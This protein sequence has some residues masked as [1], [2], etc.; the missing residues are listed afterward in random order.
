MT[1]LAP[2]SKARRLP[3]MRGCRRHPSP[4]LPVTDDPRVLRHLHGVRTLSAPFEQIK[5][6]WPWNWMERIS[7]IS[8]TQG[9]PPGSEL[10]KVILQGETPDTK[11]KPSASS[12]GNGVDKE[13]CIRGRVAGFSFEPSPVTKEMN[14]ICFLLR[15]SRGSCEV[16]FLLGKAPGDHTLPPRITTSP[17]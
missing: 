13:L 12:S 16:N 3:E 7:L 15:A 10:I 4:G 5:A 1:P 9:S 11:S 2:G 14:K 6:N 17:T 8:K